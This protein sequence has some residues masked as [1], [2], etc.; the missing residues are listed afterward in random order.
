VAAGAEPSV[1][2]S[3]EAQDVASAREAAR[4]IALALRYSA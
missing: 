2:V 1:L 3:V 4:R